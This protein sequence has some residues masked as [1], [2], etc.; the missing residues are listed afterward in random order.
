MALKKL[1]LTVPTEDL[2]S[3]ETLNNLSRWEDVVKFYSLRLILAP[4]IET[5]IL[6][7]RKMYL[8]EKGNGL[9]CNF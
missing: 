5:I 9:V 4:L 2:Y 8:L 7:D 6:L 1:D 3:V